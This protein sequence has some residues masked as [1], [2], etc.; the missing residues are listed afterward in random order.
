MSC[1]ISSSSSQRSFSPCVALCRDTIISHLWELLSS[2]GEVRHVR[3]RDCVSRTTL[4]H[5]ATFPWSQVVNSEN[6]Q[7]ISESNISQIDY[8]RGCLFACY[9]P[10][11]GDQERTSDTT[12]RRLLRGTRDGVNPRSLEMLTRFILC[13]V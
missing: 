4:G 10:I 9:W 8:F 7:R 12:K 13:K 11:L 1:H 2:S 6:I 3:T 5:N